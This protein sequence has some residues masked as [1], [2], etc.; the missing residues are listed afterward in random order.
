MEF[1]VVKA[2]NKFDLTIKSRWFLLFLGKTTP[3]KIVAGAYTRD[4]GEIVFEDDPIIIHSPVL[5]P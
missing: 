4:A 1:P 2:F 3:L 5:S